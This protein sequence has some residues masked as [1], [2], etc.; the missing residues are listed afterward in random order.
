MLARIRAIPT[1]QLTLGVALLGL[2]FLIAAQL[3]A[4]AP[5]VRYTT[6][7]RSPLIETATAL[8]AQQ[9][10]AQDADPGPAHADRRGRAGA[11]QGSA[12][13]VGGRSTTSCWRRASRP[14]SSR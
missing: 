14:D 4:E 10:D 5:R 7:E 3:A 6:Q 1:W 12:A 11:S 8:Q 2:G 9:D 13:V